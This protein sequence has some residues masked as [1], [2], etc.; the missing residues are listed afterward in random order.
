[1]TEL[2]LCASTGYTTQTHC[3]EWSIYISNFTA[4]RLSSKTKYLERSFSMKNG[5]STE[6]Q[7]IN[8]M[9]ATIVCLWSLQG[10]FTI[11]SLSA[12]LLYCLNHSFFFSIFLLSHY[13]SSYITLL[14]F[15]HSYVIALPLTYFLLYKAAPSSFAILFGSFF[16]HRFGQRVQWRQRFHS[17]SQSHPFLCPMPHKSVSQHATGTKLE[18]PALMCPSRPLQ[19]LTVSFAKKYTEVNAHRLYNMMWHDQ[20][21]ESVQYL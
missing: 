3:Q 11:Q 1:M 4:T 5:W 17:Q 21:Y 13:S 19:D 2:S 16:T 10:W 20:V 9:C 12:T 14:S 8:P 18:C 15:S 7:C 6:Q